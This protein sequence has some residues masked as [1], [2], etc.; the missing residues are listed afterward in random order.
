LEA[1][2]I[3]DHWNY[4]QKLFKKAELTTKP[5]KI[6]N[7]KVVVMGVMVVVVVW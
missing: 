7:L 5:H 1:P 3:L 4:F 6:N 2:H